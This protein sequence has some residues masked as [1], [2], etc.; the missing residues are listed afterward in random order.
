M[1]GNC[2]NVGIA[3]TRNIREYKKF[4]QNL[5]NG[6]LIRLYNNILFIFKCFHHNTPT[7]LQKHL[8]RKSPDGRLV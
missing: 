2:A 5:K 4:S 3:Q 6:E 8:T 7:A 1:F